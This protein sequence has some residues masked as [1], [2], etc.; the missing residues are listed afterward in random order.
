MQKRSVNTHIRAK[1]YVMAILVIAVIFGLSV[2]FSSQTSIK[3]GEIYNTYRDFGRKHVEYSRGVATTVENEYVH[4]GGRP[5]GISISAKGLIVVGDCAVQTK[6]GDVYPSKNLG[7][8][9][10]DI[11]ISA[12]GESVSTIYGFKET[13]KNESSVDLTFLRKTQE[14]HVTI[15]TAKDFASGENKVGLLLKEDVG[16]IGTLTFVTQKGQFASLGHFITDA[17]SGLSSELDGGHIYN[18]EIDGIIKGERGQAGG[19]V[20][21]VNRLSKPIGDIK[22]NTNIGLYGVYTKEPTGDL[23]KVASK[24]EAKIGKAQVLTTIDGD[25]P[26]FYDIDIVK[27]VSQQDVGEK[28]M[29]IV[30]RDS[31]LIE[32]TGGIV[33]GMSGSPIVQNGVLIGAV[34]H[35]FIQDPL[36]GYAVHSRFMLDYANSVKTDNLNDQIDDIGNQSGVDKDE[37]TLELYPLVA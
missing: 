25:E 11:L 22:M 30:V 23:Y 20:G 36:R 32:K 10:G 7:I 4:I 29:V 8:Q 37:Q 19:L 5:I 2:V 31:E 14:Y 16:G 9:K 34:T 33:Q 24:G 13:I 12:N 21:D 18:C 3:N 27:V 17:E 6:D 26:K 15:K 28:G 35:V 1:L